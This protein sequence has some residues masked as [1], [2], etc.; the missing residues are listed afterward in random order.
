MFEMTYRKLV[1]A[2]L[3]KLHGGRI[4]LTDGRQTHDFGDA[5]ADL[6]TAIT[7][8]K[9]EFY[10]HLVFG[11][12]IGAAESL[13]RGHWGCSDLT[14][15]IR[16]FVRNL[17]AGDTVNGRLSWLRN[18]I[19]RTGHFLRRNTIGK[20]RQNISRHYDLSNDFFALFLDHSMTYSSAIFPDAESSLQAGSLEKIDRA[21]RKLGLRSD[22][23]L[24]EI[25]TG[26]GALAIHAAKNYGCRVTTT[27]IS[28]QQHAWARRRIDE[29]QLGDR[30]TLLKQDYRDLTGQFDKLVSIE[31]IEAVGHQYF[32]TFFRKCGQ[33]LKP[34]GE[35]LL[36]SITIAD[37]RFKHHKRTVDFIKRYIFPGG[38]LPSVTAL[39]QAMAR[40]SRLRMVHMEDFADHYAETLRRW[41]AAFTDRLDDVRQLGFDERFVRI[42]NYYLCYCEAAFMERHV[43]VAQI[44]LAN[45]GSKVSP[46]AREF[47]APPVQIPQPD[48]HR[49]VQPF[50]LPEVAV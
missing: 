19:E 27:T 30:I 25:G 23:H 49:G 33:L 37:H 47:G 45:H 29:E 39:S 32:D 18:G 24:L 2:Q 9:A 36:Q 15:L 42:W 38:C 22:D 3:S 7:V 11:G 20:A 4:T 50:L 5:Q 44:W 8:H 12:G 1:L 43:N 35:M 14:A 17:P 40:S 16:I 34:D 21:C 10:R 28:E 6:S 48:V 13:T 46:L 26:W 41:R 31:M